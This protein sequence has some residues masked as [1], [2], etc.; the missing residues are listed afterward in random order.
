VLRPSD[1][2]RS[3]GGAGRIESIGTG[4]GTGGLVTGLTL[5]ELGIDKPRRG[6]LQHVRPAKGGACTY[7]GPLLPFRG[8]GT[9]ARRTGTGDDM[10]T[11]LVMTVEDSKRQS[12]T[13]LSLSKP[14]TATM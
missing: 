8:P 9:G 1:G 13:L 10:A 4:S 3:V 5:G 14:V 12:G 6:A 7:L 11:M 2:R